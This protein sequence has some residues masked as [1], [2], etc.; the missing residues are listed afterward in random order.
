M[1]KYK[2]L[3]QFFYMFTVLLVIPSLGFSFT[4]SNIHPR[5]LLTPNEMNTLRARRGLANSFVYLMEGS[6]DYFL[7]AQAL[8]DQISAQV[9]QL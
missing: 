6:S 5:I 3:C 8:L 2:A 4:V 7:K 9:K 1:N